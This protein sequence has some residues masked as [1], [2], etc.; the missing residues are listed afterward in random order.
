MFPIRQE[1]LDIL[2]DKFVYFDEKNT[3]QSFTGLNGHI[4]NLESINRY[5][6]SVEDGGDLIFHDF[7][8]NGEYI[9]RIYNSSIVDSF[10]TEIRKEFGDGE[11]DGWNKLSKGLWVRVFHIDDDLSAGISISEQPTLIFSSHYK[12][13]ND[14]ILNFLNEV[15]LKGGIPSVNYINSVN[16]MGFIAHITSWNHIAGVEDNDLQVYI[17]YTLKKLMKRYTCPCCGYKTLRERNN[18]ETCQVCKWMDDDLQSIIPDIAGGANK[19]SLREAQKNFQEIGRA[20]KTYFH[21]EPEPSSNYEK[22]T[23]WRPLD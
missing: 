20:S 22:D 5:V 3:I 14:E 8:L 19:E 15:G 13:T 18:W 11:Y 12:L 2:D 10:I 6:L 4:P 16:K 7:E 23:N 17:I 21:S 1:P 9:Y